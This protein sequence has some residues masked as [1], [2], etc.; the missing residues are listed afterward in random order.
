MFDPDPPIRRLAKTDHTIVSLA[1]VDSDGAPVP[2]PHVMRV[3]AN[4]FKCLATYIDS[5]T[6]FYAPYWS[7]PMMFKSGLG[8]DDWGVLGTARRET[9][10]LH[11]SLRQERYMELSC[12]VFRPSSVDRATNERIPRAAIAFDYSAIDAD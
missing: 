3:G 7:C 10:I 11:A 12:W 4:E 8:S 9:A 2:S 5:S 1:I 6:A